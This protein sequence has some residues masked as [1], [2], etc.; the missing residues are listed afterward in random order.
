MPQV[1]TSIFRKYDIRGTVSGDNPQ[2]TPELANLVGKAFGT[3]MPKTFGTERVFVGSDNRPSSP[4]IKQALMEGIA[5]TGLD[6]TDIGAVLTPTVYFA[7]ASFE[8]KGAGVQIT[9]SHLDTRYNGIKMAYGPLALADEQIQALLE[10]IQ[11]DAFATGS[12]TISQD[13]DMIHKHMKTIQGKVQIAKP[14]T[15]VLDAGNGLSGTY[16]PPVLEALGITVHCLYCESDGT[17]PNHLP[18]PED[19]EMTKDLEAKVIEV[20]ADLGLA[21]DGDADR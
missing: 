12:G 3:Y 20:G 14:L 17:Y 2:I 8:G 10:I 19:P 16:V 7:S 1:I 13:L 9:G 21:F 18:N 5:S 4:A 11:T 15:V 6:V